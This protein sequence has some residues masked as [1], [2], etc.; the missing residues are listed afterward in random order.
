MP[1]D[2]HLRPEAM[3]A[4]EVSRFPQLASTTTSPHQPF[5]APPTTF[6]SLGCQLDDYLPK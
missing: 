5:L 4:I 6:S 1:N 2:T 3:I